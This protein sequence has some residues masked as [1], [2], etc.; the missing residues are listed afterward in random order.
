MSQQTQL[1]ELLQQILEKVP[2]PDELQP[3]LAEVGQFAPELRSS[4]PAADP[5]CAPGRHEDATVSEDAAQARTAVKAL[6]RSVLLALRPR[7]VGNGDLPG[8][9]PKMASAQASWTPPNLFSTPDQT[10]K[11][12][13]SST[14][15]DF[16]SPFQSPSRGMVLKPAEEKGVQTSAE[17]TLSQQNA[18]LA[19]AASP[20]LEQV[21][22]VPKPFALRPSAPEFYPGAWPAWPQ[23]PALTR[24]R[25]QPAPRSK[26]ALSTPS[27]SPVRAQ[28]KVGV[29]ESLGVLPVPAQCSPAPTQA[30]A[31]ELSVSP[32]AA[33]PTTTT[34]SDVAEIV[35]DG[36][37]KKNEKNVIERIQILPLGK[38]EL[39][40][41]LID[42]L[43]PL[44]CEMRDQKKEVLNGQVLKVH[45]KDFI[46]VKT[47]PA[48]RGFLTKET[49][50]FFAGNP[51]ERFDTI[52]LRGLKPSAGEVA[53]LAEDALFDLYVGPFFQNQADNGGDSFGGVLSVLT[54]NETLDI[55]G[56]SF[57][58]TATEPAN[59]VGVVDHNTTIYVGWDSPP[60]SEELHVVPSEAQDN[61]AEEK[62]TYLAKLAE[63]AGRHEEMAELMQLAA[64]SARAKQATGVMPVE[65]CI[66]CDQSMHC[67]AFVRKTPAGDNICRYCE[68]DFLA[69]EQ[70]E[71][72]RTSLG[73]EEVVQRVLADPRGKIST[74]LREATLREVSAEDREALTAGAVEEWGADFIVYAAANGTRYRVELREHGHRQVNLKT[75]TERFVCREPPPLP[76]GVSFDW[77]FTW[78]G[79]MA[80]GAT[81]AYEAAYREAEVRGQ[82]PSQKEL[83]DASMEVPYPEAVS[84]ALEALRRAQIRAEIPESERV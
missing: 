24:G 77:N 49:S 10:P 13:D 25:Q 30:S 44:L 37:E 84:R 8:Y 41:A 6:P 4:R 40:T 56:V 47:D 38:Q 32:A 39:T 28:Q 7:H 42:I 81:W 31:T 82:Q 73:G 74:E 21:R 52:Q 69:C 3:A 19:G 67:S 17:A 75:G 2:L 79:L 54:T 46:V 51:V 33:A 66:W 61:N 9:M 43:A 76:P 83:S 11:A 27:A 34:P 15:D 16:E 12:V 18:S 58:V 65:V 60:K 36:A 48:G 64:E 14:V 80:P 23:S 22:T 26:P 62:F 70:E 59:A 53:S 71:L 63:Q 78:E 45:G 29:A 35:A 57:V 20:L 5:A 50:Y 1:V 72:V 68:A 55:L